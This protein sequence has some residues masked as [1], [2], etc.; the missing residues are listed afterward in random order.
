M[1]RACPADRSVSNYTRRLTIPVLPPRTLASPP[2]AARRVSWG[3]YLEDGSYVV[4]NV[5]LRGASPR[6]LEDGRRSM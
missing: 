5:N 4:E 2:E 6:H 1:P 3:D